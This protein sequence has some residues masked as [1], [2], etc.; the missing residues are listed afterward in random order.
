MDNIN[1]H[2]DGLYKSNPLVKDFTLIK[3]CLENN[4]Q[5]LN[6]I[7]NLNIS[8]PNT[9]NYIEPNSCPIYS[10]ITDPELTIINGEPSV[11]KYNI[12][13]TVAHLNN[14]PSLKLKKKYNTYAFYK[15]SFYDKY[16]YYNPVDI[17]ETQC[18]GDKCRRDFHVSDCGI[19]CESCHGDFCEYISN[20]DTIMVRKLNFAQFPKESIL[21]IVPIYIP[22]D[23]NNLENLQNIINKLTLNRDNLEQLDN[24]INNWQL[25]MEKYIEKYKKECKK[26]QEIN[27]LKRNELVSIHGLD[28]NDYNNLIKK[29]NDT[30]SKI[31]LEN[32]ITEQTKNL[33]LLEDELLKQKQSTEDK[34]KFLEME[35]SQVQKNIN[36][37]KK[38][39]QEIEDKKKLLINQ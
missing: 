30:I 13:F 11:I 6:Q 16:F 5:Y 23:Y 1:L 18:H 31:K 14:K 33:K 7:S 2:Y 32:E 21:N 36:L 15:Y 37:I 17:K 19:W 39:N 20:L 34:K 24:K 9:D 10:G 12:L 22:V 28:I 26:Q 35:L 25:D 4:K 8:D 3:Y 27:I 29:F 38:Y